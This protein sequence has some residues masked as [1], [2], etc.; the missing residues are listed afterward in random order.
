MELLA[1]R[2]P[3]DARRLLDA[4]LERMIEAVHHYEGTVN[5]VLGDGIMAL[6][7]APL[8][9]ENHAVRA[10]YAALRMQE[11]VGAVR[12]RDAA[13]PRGAHPDPR[14]PQLRRGRGRGPSAATS[15]WSTRRSGR[16]PTWPRG[17]SR[18]PSRPPCSSRP[19]PCGWPRDTSRPGALGPGAGPRPGRPGRGV[20]AGRRH[21]RPDAPPGR[22]RAGAH[23]ARR[24]PG[25]AGAAAPGAGAGSERARPGR[26]PRRRGRRRE[27]APRL[28]D[29]ALAPDPATGWSSRAARCPTARRRPGCP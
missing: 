3:E 18:W 5:Q 11:D 20:R 6:F 12:G 14:R 19:T 24:A 13:R 26:G 1:D 28:G 25:R 23:P 8:A 17:W 9:H 29:H 4:V 10:C 15:G 22:G 7:G 21:G 16:P 27:V 2:D